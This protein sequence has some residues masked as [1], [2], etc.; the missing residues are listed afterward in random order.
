MSLAYQIN[1]VKVEKV[2]GLQV[3]GLRVGSVWKTGNLL[4]RAPERGSTLQKKM[5]VWARA[6]DTNGRLYIMWEADNPRARSLVIQ[7]LDSHYCFE[8]SPAES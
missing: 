5:R 6:K 1:H 8:V 4:L 7:R 2:V 3:D